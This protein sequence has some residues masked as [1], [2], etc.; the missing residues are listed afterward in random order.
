MLPER[1]LHRARCWKLDSVKHGHILDGVGRNLKD[2]MGELI[3]CNSTDT[4]DVEL[5]N[6]LP[7]NWAQMW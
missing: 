5:A 2:Q 1:I 6:S 4:L 7:Q 3:L